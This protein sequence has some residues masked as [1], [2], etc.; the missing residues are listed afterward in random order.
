MIFLEYP[1][2][3]YL[4]HSSQYFLLISVT[5]GFG[6]FGTTDGIL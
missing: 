5:I 1:V 3:L 2:Q 6:T 4:T